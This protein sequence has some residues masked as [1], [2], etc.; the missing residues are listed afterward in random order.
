MFK[1]SRISGDLPYHLASSS[2]TGETAEVFCFG[3]GA[4][5]FFLEKRATVLKVAGLE[6]DG[7]DLVTPLKLMGLPSISDMPREAMF[8][9]ASTNSGGEGVAG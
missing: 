7:A 4:A 3:G 9:E 2:S 1:P 5:A 6:G 8:E